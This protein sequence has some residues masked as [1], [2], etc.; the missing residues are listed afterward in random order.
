MPTYTIGMR[1][2][3]RH[4]KEGV[5][6]IT[7]VEALKA[8]GPE[9]GLYLT[10]AAW[11]EGYTYKTHHPM[12]SRL[13]DSLITL[14]PSNSPDGILVQSWYEEVPCRRWQPTAEDLIA[15]DWVLVR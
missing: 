13:Y 4:Q 12:G 14:I 3:Y 2:D 5:R 15:E 10:R 6:G 1:F 8:R 11:N 9:N 7:I